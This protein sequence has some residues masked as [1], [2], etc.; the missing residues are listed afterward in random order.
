MGAPVLNSVLPVV[1]G[2]DF[3]APRKLATTTQAAPQSYSVDDILNL[4]SS[5]YDGMKSVGDTGYFLKG[6]KLYE[7]YTPAPAN[8]GYMYG[9]YGGVNQGPSLA[10]GSIKVGDQDFKPV[11]SGS[12]PGFVQSDDDTYEISQAYINANKPKYQG[13]PQQNLMPLLSLANTPQNTESNGESYGA[14]RFIAPTTL[15]ALMNANTAEGES[16]GL[17]GGGK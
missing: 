8:N 15:D 5:E 14:G 13:T 17:L 10:E 12:I 11:K 7:T 2:L 6:G 9:I 16:A 3:N 1:N 4:S